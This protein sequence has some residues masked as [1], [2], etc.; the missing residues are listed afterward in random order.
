MSKQ[1]NFGVVG[2]GRIG[3]DFHCQEASKNPR[4]NL[5]GVADPMQNRLDEAHKTFA[6]AGFNNSEELFELKGLKAVAIAAPTHLHKKLCLAAFKKG[7]H[8]MLEKPM[9]LNLK[10]AQ[11]IV[12]AAKEYKCKLTIYQPHRQQAYFQQ[13]K[14][15]IASGI[16]GEIFH[17]RRGIFNYVQRDDWQSLRKYG[18][19]MLLNY[20]AHGLDQLLDMA[21][22]DVKNV[23]CQL[24][25]VLSLGDT[26]D[27]VK[28]VFKT[29][30]GI[31]CELDVNQASTLTPYSFEVT[32][33][34]GCLSQKGDELHLKYVKDGKLPQKTLNK[35][36]ASA[37]RKYPSEKINFI[38][39]KVKILPKYT[40]DFYDNFA[41]ALQ[42][43]KQL[44]VKPEQTIAVMKLIEKCRKEAGQLVCVR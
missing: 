11:I 18:G 29:K 9:A 17:I 37:D 40:I 10:E 19:G 32:G 41:D 14:D 2:L 27:V 44:L 30:Q 3:W 38:E 42:K 33:H 23:F 43:R 22:T 6:A 8:V 16:L 26:E 15:I 12:K 7:L 20:G 5:I 39:K 34:L 13:I 35:S 1:I 4:F 36:L 25:K 28:V 21:G 24:Q 31:T